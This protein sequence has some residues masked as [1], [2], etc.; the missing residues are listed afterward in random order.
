[1]TVPV[2]Q[3]QAVIERG[4]KADTLLQNEAFLWIVD[5]Q[6]NYHLAALCAAP[7]GATGADAVAYHHLQQHALTELVATLRGYVEAGEQQ[8]EA[9][10]WGDPEEPKN[11]R[12]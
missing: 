4:H 7:P 10:E 5:D 1:M 11:D 6:T 2:D 3:A 9:L 12:S 8:R